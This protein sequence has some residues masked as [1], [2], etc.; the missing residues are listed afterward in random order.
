MVYRTAYPPERME[1]VGRSPAT[2]VPPPAALLCSSAGAPLA[3]P[4]LQDI[5]ARNLREGQYFVTGEGILG[6]AYCQG[7]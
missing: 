4:R 6:R 5:L 2:L 7:D 1:N 3:L